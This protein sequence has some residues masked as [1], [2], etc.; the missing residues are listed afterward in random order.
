MLE[1]IVNN[2][3]D[4]NLTIAKKQAENERWIDLA[5]AFRDYAGYS[6]NKSYLCAAYLRALVIIN[7]RAMRSNHHA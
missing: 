2:Y 3:I 5:D 1:E 6:A 4:G 7:K